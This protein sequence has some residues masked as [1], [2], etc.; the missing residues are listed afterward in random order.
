MHLPASISKISAS[1]DLTNG[2]LKIFIKGK[3]PES[4]K[5]ETDFVAL[6]F[7]IYLLIAFTTIYSYL[8]NISIVLSVYLDYM[9]GCM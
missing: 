9:G 4:S 8:H 1:A 6:G 3:A 2:G 5:I 7:I